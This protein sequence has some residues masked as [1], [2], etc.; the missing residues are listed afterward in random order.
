MSQKHWPAALRAKLACISEAEQAF[1]GAFYKIS[2]QAIRYYKI[3]SFYLPTENTKGLKR[4]PFEGS[5]N[6]MDV[7]ILPPSGCA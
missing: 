3:Y 7:V 5:I 4:R 2:I 1:Q 6:G